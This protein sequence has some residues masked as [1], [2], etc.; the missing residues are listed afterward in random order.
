MTRT[1]VHIII[2]SGKECDTKLNQLFDFNFP[3]IDGVLNMLSQ[4]TVTWYT[5]YFKLK[6]FN[7]QQ[8]HE[9]FSDLL[10]LT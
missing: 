2:L 6:K 10:G 8:V 9:G 4:N 5:E 7:K 3:S 1:N